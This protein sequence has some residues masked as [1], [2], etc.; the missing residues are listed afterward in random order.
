ALDKVTGAVG[1]SS[2]KAFALQTM[3]EDWTRVA[4]VVD[5]LSKGDTLD[6]AVSSMRRTLFDYHDLTDTERDTFRAIA[7]FYTWTRKNL[8][9]QIEQMIERPERF[10]APAK[11]QTETERG[12]ST[13]PA[14][15]R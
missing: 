3:Y 13:V 1:A 4:H 15:V 2:N 14:N 11:A 5:R 12:R 10:T 6:E 9:Y 8:P 7:P